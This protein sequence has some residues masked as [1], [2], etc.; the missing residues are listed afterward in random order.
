MSD[1]SLSGPGAGRTSFGAALAGLV[2][3]ACV[4]GLA[5]ILVRLT[6]TGPAAAGLWRLGV[7]TPLLFL[8]AARER[9][10]GSAGERGGRAALW[11]AAAGLL[12][13]GDLA[14]WHYGVAFTSVTNATV[15][16]NLAPVVVALI[17]WLIFRERPKAVFVVALALALG[18]ALAM[19]LAK[20]SGGVGTNPALGNAF[21]A[22][23][24]LFYGA[25]FVVMRLARGFAG[26]GRLMAWS[27]LAG[28]PVMLAAALALG[29]ALLPATGAGLLACLGLG[30]V[31]VGGQGSIAWALGRLPAAT[32]SVA[33]FVQPV[34]AALFGWALFGEAVT[35]G[36]ALGGAVALVGVALAQWSARRAERG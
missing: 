21:S 33:V 9:S 30:L 29:E 11:G 25:Y 31:H 2:F 22:L 8:L 17:A 7:A 10:A 24:A 3:G 18:G 19:A 14:F 23:T 12:F 13:A 34:V 26:A 6:E 20:G 15:L 16:S 4:I 32:A 28:V 36:Q 1:A 5:P 27:T 35:A